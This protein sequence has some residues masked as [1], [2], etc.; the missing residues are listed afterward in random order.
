MKIETKRLILRPFEES[1]YGKTLMCM[2]YG[3][4]NNN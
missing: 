2:L 3:M 1:D 4:K